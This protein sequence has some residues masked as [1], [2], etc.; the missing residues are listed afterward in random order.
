MGISED[1]S[2]FEEPAVNVLAAPGLRVPFESRP[3]TYVTDT[4][5]DGASGFTVAD[6]AYYR[7]R[8]SDGDL[9]EVADPAKKKG[10]N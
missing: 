2:R 3:W 5:P 7:R 8:V 10:S 1:F 4:P 9:V 6:T